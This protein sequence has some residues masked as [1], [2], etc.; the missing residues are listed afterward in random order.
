M[1]WLIDVDDQ[2][3]IALELADGPA[4]GFLSLT[5]TAQSILVCQFST[6]T[7]LGKPMQWPSHKRG[8][9]FS[10]KHHAHLCEYV[11]PYQGLYPFR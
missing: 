2:G 9:V 4:P 3:K 10:R 11:P 1:G 5:A 7:G 8:R 6:S